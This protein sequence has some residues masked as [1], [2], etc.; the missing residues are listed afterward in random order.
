ML[1]PTQ[2]PCKWNPTFYSSV[3]SHRAHFGRVGADAS[4]G[5]RCVRLSGVIR[6]LL[7]CRSVVWC[8]VKGAVAGSSILRRVFV[9][10]AVLGV[11]QWFCFSKQW[12]RYCWLCVHTNTGRRCCAALES[13]VSQSHQRIQEENSSVTNGCSKKGWSE[14]WSARAGIFLKEYFGDAF[15]HSGNIWESQPRS[16]KNQMVTFLQGDVYILCKNI[17]VEAFRTLYYLVVKDFCWKR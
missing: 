17:H 15:V 1:F 11:R 7:L 9:G 16:T 10:H 5:R 13:D 6:S 4:Q 2:L 14:D 8:G 12:E 3:R